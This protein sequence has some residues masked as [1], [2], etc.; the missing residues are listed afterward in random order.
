MD[1]SLQNLN[2]IVLPDPVGWLPLAPG[3]QSLL[4]LLALALLVLIWR[5]WLAWR[6]NRYRREALRELAAMT[7]LAGLPS[8]LKRAALSAYPRERVAAINGA[9][10]HRFLDES[11]GF[12]RFVSGCGEP[13]DRLAYGGPLPDENDA[14]ALR[15]AARAWIEQ[16]RRTD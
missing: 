1:G 14:Q 10:W 16:H 5:R 11:A 7:N 6:D 8:L 4:V 9:E 3:L 15:E 2:P 12:D 13:L